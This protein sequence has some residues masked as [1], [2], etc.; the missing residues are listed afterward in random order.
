M[1]VSVLHGAQEVSGESMNHGDRT[2]PPLQSALQAFS[3]DPIADAVRQISDDSGIVDVPYSGMV[4]PAECLRFANE[5]GPGCLIGV[6]VHPQ[7]DSPLQ[8]QILRFEEYPL[9]RDRH[10]S[11]KTVALAKR[12]VGAI[13]VAVRLDRGQRNNPRR[14]S[15]F[16]WRP[17]TAELHQ[18]LA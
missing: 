7:P 12:R 15:T 2:G 6:E 8:D 16:T 1:A 14:R 11:F 10:R 9:R 5:P 17:H 3:I 4:E 13:V 18:R